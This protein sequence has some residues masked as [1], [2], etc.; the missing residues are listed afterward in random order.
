MSNEYKIES[1]KILDDFEISKIYNT[2][3]PDHNP[4][5]ECELIIIPMKY[6]YSVEY[7]SQDIQSLISHKNKHDFVNEI[8]K[9][10]KLTCSISYNSELQYLSEWISLFPQKCLY[11]ID[12]YWKPDNWDGLETHIKEKLNADCYDDF[13]SIKLYCI[14]YNNS[15][16]SVS[17]QNLEWKK[18]N[19]FKI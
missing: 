6:L 13:S 10:Q 19:I 18:L 16:I 7:N 5:S 8:S 9:A 15:F 3:F 17:I 1:Y 12:E 14:Y 11:S 2:K 4:M